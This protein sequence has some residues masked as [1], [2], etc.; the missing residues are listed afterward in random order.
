MSQ[1]INLELT[2]MKLLLAGD[3]D[4]LVGLRR[5]FETSTVTNREFTGVGFFTTFG[6]PVSVPKVAEGKSFKFGDV[7]ASVAGLQHGAGFLLFVKDGVLKMLEGYSYD[8]PW[9]KQITTFE[10]SYEKNCRNWAALR[11]NWS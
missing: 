2:V 9:P 11:A 7:N 4:V 6:V 10:L 3:D 5:Q 1:L 8:E